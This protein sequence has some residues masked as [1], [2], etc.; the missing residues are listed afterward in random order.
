MFGVQGQTKTEGALREWSDG[1]LHISVEPSAN[2][3]QLR[4]N[5]RKDDAVA[6]NGAG[7]LLIVVGVVL[8]A[9]LAATGKPGTA[10]GVLGFFGAISLIPFFAAN[11]IRTPAWARERE[12]QIEAILNDV[13]KLL[14]AKPAKG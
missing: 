4:V 12:R 9:F 11:L 7:F 5:D 14:D 6:I 3:N 1:N 13:V 10:G 2:G 8:G